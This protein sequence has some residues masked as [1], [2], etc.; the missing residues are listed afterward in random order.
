MLSLIWATTC[1]GLNYFLGRARQ[2]HGTLGMNHG[3]IRVIMGYLAGKS[4]AMKGV[5]YC[6]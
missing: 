4:T 5:I 6:V 3:W 2:E 1:K